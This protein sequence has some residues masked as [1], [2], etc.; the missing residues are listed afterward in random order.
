MPDVGENDA[1]GHAETTRLLFVTPRGEDGAVTSAARQRHG[2]GALAR[3]RSSVLTSEPAPPD[4][5]YIPP[6]F[7]D[8]LDQHLVFNFNGFDEWP[9]VLGVFGRPGDGKSFQIR[10]HLARRGVTPVSINAA[11][12]E[13][14]R[15]G[16]PGKLVLDTYVDAGHRIDEGS[17][18][19]LVVDDF[20]TTV[21]EWEHST[22][23]V[24]HQQVL[25]QLMHLADSPTE[26]AGKRLRRV[27]VIITGN[28][29]SKVY[30]P[31]RRPGR[32]RAFPW[33]PTADERQEIVAGILSDVLAPTDVAG[34]LAT[35]PEAPV[36]FFSDLLVEI[37]AT[38]SDGEVRSQAADL[39]ALIRAGNRS[40][41]A[42]MQHASN[43]RL[44][45]SEVT[46]LAVQIWDNRTLATQSHLGE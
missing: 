1:S 23:T 21:G 43:N 8:A 29:L 30:P 44:D 16:T 25:A 40:R 7:A 33:L 4:R 36:A 12:L 20:D 42:L 41:E 31:L 45:A 27:P 32:L 3:D 18:A 5:P 15:A 46:D 38:V 35:L 19:A 28:D 22:T 11:D 9:L 13:S 24:N 34:L 37:L 39:T 17:P 10:T 14:D 26:A 2:T 6:R